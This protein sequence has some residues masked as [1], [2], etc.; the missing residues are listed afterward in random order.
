[1]GTLSKIKKKK[2]KTTSVNNR[3]SGVPESQRGEPELPGA[4]VSRKSQAKDR[5]Q[6]SSVPH[7]HTKEA[8]PGFPLLL[9][10]SFAHRAPSSQVCVWRGSGR[11]RGTE[12][13]LSGSSAIMSPPPLPL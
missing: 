5:A 1:M 6:E 10:L 8:L 9:P 2:K 3:K 13:G 4:L 12:T 7:V 11:N